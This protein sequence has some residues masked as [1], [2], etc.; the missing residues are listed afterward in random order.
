MNDFACVKVFQ[1]LHNHPA[2]ASQL[3]PLQLSLVY[4]LSKVPVASLHDEVCS[5]G[6][7]LSVGFLVSAIQVDNARVTSFLHRGTQNKY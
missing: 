2:K 3:L 1:G 5:L 4:E 6:H 7:P